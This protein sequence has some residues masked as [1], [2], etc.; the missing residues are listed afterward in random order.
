VYVTGE[1]L[2]RDVILGDGSSLRL[3]APGPEDYED[4]K[5]FY[6]RLSGESLYMRFHGI[7]RTDLAARHLVD[8]G[9]VERLALIC[10]QGD[11]VL[12]AASYD[13]LLEPDV[14]E[15]SFA[16]A[17]EQRAGANR[18]ARP[19]RCGRVAASGARP[20]FDRDRGRDGR[21]G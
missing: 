11:R 10:R 12:A 19:S 7:A 16:V 13:R 18:R 8:A 17:E 4:V 15:V 9:G 5:A 6:D 20:H 21:P 14:A 2:V 3:V 1:R